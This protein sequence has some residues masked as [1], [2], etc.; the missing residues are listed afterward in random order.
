MTS[1]P[2]VPER[3]R[4]ERY[5]LLPMY[6]PVAVRRLDEEHVVRTGHAYD[7]ADGGIRFELDD[8]IP[9]GTPVLIEFVL[10]VQHRD[11]GRDGEPTPAILAYANIVRVI[12]EDEEAPPIRMAAAFTRFARA[13]DRERL[14]RRVQTGGLAQAA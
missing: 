6:A 1:T 3:R 4:H 8:P 10:P 7:V 14:A 5:R 13:E 11:G 9:A 2:T 12:E